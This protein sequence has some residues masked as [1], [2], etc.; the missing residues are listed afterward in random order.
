MEELVDASMKFTRVLKR[1]G[2]SQ[3]TLQVAVRARPLSRKGSRPA[4]QTTV[5]G[6][7]EQSPTIGEW[8]GSFASPPYCSVNQFIA[9]PVSRKPSAKAAR[10]ECCDTSLAT[11]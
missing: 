1:K 3:A 8:R 5:G 4:V 10:L 2:V 9:A 6:V 11:G 7:F